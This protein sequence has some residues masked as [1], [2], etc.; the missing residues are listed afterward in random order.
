MHLVAYAQCAQSGGLQCVRDQTQRHFCVPQFGQRQRHAI[1]SDAA[2][3]NGE[4]RHTRRHAQLHIGLR[5]EG[6]HR[7]HITH[8]VDMPGHEVPTKAIT[9]AQCALKVHG[10][11]KLQA[12]K[13]REAQSLAHQVETG[14]PTINSLYRQT[15]APHAQRIAHPDALR[16]RAQVNP[17]AQRP[18]GFVA[19]NNP[20]YGFNDSREHAC[21]V[22]SD[23]RLPNPLQVNDFRAARPTPSRTRAHCLIPLHPSVSCAAR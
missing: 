22:A 6:L 10:I 14:H 7:Q 3:R 16:R 9:D 13:I 19:I 4:L 1:H 12:C 18:T 15:T 20:A 11:A 17:Q 21:S 5:G 2:L 8:T 23:A